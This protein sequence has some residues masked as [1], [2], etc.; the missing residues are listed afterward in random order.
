M[1]NTV[2]SWY[3][4]ERK[5]RFC[6]VLQ[7]PLITVRGGGRNHIQGSIQGWNFLG[8]SA[9]RKRPL[10]SEAWLLILL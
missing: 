10:D 9:G 1:V 7:Q 2:C 4:K 5:E 8:G 3:K 6:I